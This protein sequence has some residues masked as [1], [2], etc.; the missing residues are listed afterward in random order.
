MERAVIFANGELKFSPEQCHEIRKDDF[1]IA[2]DGGALHCRKLG[3]KPNV[4]IGDFDSL[5]P[6]GENKS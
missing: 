5:N 2:A 1:I 3:I 4:V 6:E